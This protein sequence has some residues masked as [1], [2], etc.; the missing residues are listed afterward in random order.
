MHNSQESDLSSAASSLS[1]VSASATQELEQEITSDLNLVVPSTSSNQRSLLADIRSQFEHVS[2]SQGNQRQTFF[3]HQSETN[4]QNK[5]PIKM[6]NTNGIGGSSNQGPKTTVIQIKGNNVKINDSSGIREIK[7]P[8]SG[9]DRLS[10]RTVN[11]NQTASQMAQSGAHNSV[12]GYKAGGGN[13]NRLGVGDCGECVVNSTVTV[14]AV[15][16]GISR[17]R[18]D[19]NS[20]NNLSESSPAGQYGSSRSESAGRSVSPKPRPQFGGSSPLASL[21][22]STAPKRVPSPASDNTDSVD[23][24]LPSNESR[25]INGIQSSASSSPDIR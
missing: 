24:S 21:L 10:P 12:H 4:L 19:S 1:S 20:E 16:N 9:V 11:S 6:S 17:L 22:V 23:G 13:A 7:T 5:Q 25:E 15:S 2:N 3:V 14:N 8:P 18:V